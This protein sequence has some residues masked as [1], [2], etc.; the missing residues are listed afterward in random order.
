MAT[1]CGIVTAQGHTEET[2]WEDK[3]SQA[4]FDQDGAAGVF[5]GGHWQMDYQGGDRKEQSSWYGG[6][7]EHVN[8]QQDHV[9]RV[10]LPPWWHQQVIEQK[11]FEQ[12]GFDST[13]VLP[14]KPPE[15]LPKEKCASAKCA[16][17][18]AWQCIIKACAKCCKQVGCPR[19]DSAYQRWLVTQNRF[20]RAN[21]RRGGKSQP[22]KY[23]RK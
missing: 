7:D 10:I 5:G 22:N 6:H 23:V 13:H 11:A 16:N 18:A 14:P 2:V 1:F 9:P 19:H 3:W 4:N 20:F 12:E 8:R 15:P 21:R 17:P